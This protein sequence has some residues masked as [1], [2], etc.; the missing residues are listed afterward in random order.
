M[1]AHDLQFFQ[2]SRAGDDRG[3]AAELCPVQCGVQHECARGWLVACVT[4]LMAPAYPSRDMKPL[5]WGQFGIICE[6]LGASA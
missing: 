1:R 3:N 2:V 5:L 6:D 4:A